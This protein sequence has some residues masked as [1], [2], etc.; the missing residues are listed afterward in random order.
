VC[1]QKFTDSTESGQNSITSS[2]KLK[3]LQFDILC[4]EIFDGSYLGNPYDIHNSLHLGFSA[5]R[6]M[7][8]KR[9][10]VTYILTNK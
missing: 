5:C 7:P 2:S 10:P 3:K 4:D 8:T 6:K 1:E 9:V